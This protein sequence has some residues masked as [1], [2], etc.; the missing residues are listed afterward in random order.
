MIDLADIF[1]V[2]AAILGIS[3]VLFFLAT[4][5]FFYERFIAPDRRNRWRYEGVP[6][7]GLYRVAL[8]DGRVELAYSD[9]KNWLGVDTVPTA[10]CER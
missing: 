7:R 4:V 3:A 10:W 9:G 5:V 2:A 8:S 1:I 6:P